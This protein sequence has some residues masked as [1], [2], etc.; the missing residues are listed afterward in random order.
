MRSFRYVVADVFTDTPLEGN[1]VAVF[2]EH[3]RLLIRPQRLRLLKR[4]RERTSVRWQ[5]LETL[6][7]GNAPMP[8]PGFAW[9]LYYQVTGNAT[10]GRKAAEYAFS[11]SADLRQQ[12]E[13][14]ARWRSPGARGHRR[15]LVGRVPVERLCVAVCPVACPEPCG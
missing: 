14:A 6:V 10:F 7:A 2:T 4:E 13:G 11:P 3:P 8:E 15:G 9:A 1:P 12:A 5:Q